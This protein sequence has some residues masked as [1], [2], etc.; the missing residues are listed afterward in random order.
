MNK[1]TKYIQE[2]RKWSSSSSD[3]ALNPRFKQA[4]NMKSSLKPI[5]SGQR[6]N[7]N[8]SRRKHYS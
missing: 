6:V 8:K 5:R 7:N 3:S 4:S 1:E 2:K